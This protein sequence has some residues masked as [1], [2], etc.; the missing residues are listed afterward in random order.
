MET[1]DV[2]LSILLKNLCVSKRITYW[3][4]FTTRGVRPGD[5]FSP[6]LFIIAMEGLNIVVKSAK[7]NSLVH[8]IKLPFNGP[9]L[10]HLFYAD[11]AIFAG[12]WYRKSIINLS[13]ILKCFHISSGLKVNF[14]KSRLF[15]IGT[16]LKN[17]A[18]IMGCVEDSFHIKYLGV[19]VGANM[20]LKKHWKLIIEKL[21][22]RLSDWKA[23]SLSFGGRITLIKYVQLA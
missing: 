21:R 14:H 1:M 23:I 22:T 3:W 12:E 11:D 6:F 20:G 18:R 16:E 8:G 19:P 4:I 17:M 5:L 9:H 13:P 7:E 10:S 15:G 2:W